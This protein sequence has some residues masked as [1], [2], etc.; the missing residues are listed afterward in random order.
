MLGVNGY[1]LNSL[2]FLK[3]V[4]FL[5]YYDSF[6]V[7]GFF[8]SYYFFIEVYACPRI[9]CCIA[10]LFVIALKSSAR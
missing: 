8:Q 10:F 1:F 9:C 2:N 5:R 3:S 4:F 7:A 6:I